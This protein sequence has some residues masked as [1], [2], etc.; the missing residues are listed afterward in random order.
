MIRT[1]FTI[2]CGG[3]LARLLVTQFTI[4]FF[5]EVKDALVPYYLISNKGYETGPPV[6]SPYPR[7]LE[8]LTICRCSYKGSTL[9]SVILRPCLLVRP[10][11]N[12]RPPA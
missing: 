2:L 4:I 3:L 7:R 10:E 6:Y 12:S 9:S 5:M 1:N 11:S 8:S